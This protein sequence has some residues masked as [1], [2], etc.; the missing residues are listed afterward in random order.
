MTNNSIVEIEN[1]RK[2]AKMEHGEDVSSSLVIPVIY[3]GSSTDGEYI[4]MLLTSFM[5]A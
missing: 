1:Q 3:S 5:Y 4:A 2:A